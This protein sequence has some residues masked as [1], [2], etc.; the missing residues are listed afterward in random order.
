MGESKDDTFCK[1][2]RAAT[3]EIHAVS[4]AL[5][6]AKLAF[7]LQDDKVWADGLL[8]FYDIFKY[9]E[10]TM[11]GI[12]KKYEI[13]NLISPEMERTKAFEEDLNYYLGNE[14]NKNHSSR[15]SVK[16]YLAHLKAVESTKPILLLAYVYHLY[17]GLLSGGIILRKKR[18]IIQ[19]ISPFKST[20]KLE[21]NR[22]TDFGKNSIYQL[23]EN[24]RSRMNDLAEG[25]D[26]ETKGQL[27][28]ES[29]V[30][31]VMNN[32]IIRS[33]RGASAVMMRKII[34]VVTIF[35]VLVLYFIFKR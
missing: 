24:F 11:P 18:Q 9:L 20:D 34:Y 7:G 13:D 26:D 27:I 14:W 8:V 2:M 25:L 10:Q 33:V 29:K 31:F 17:M 5:V 30:V 4:D 35:L 12:I 23:K 16:S 21:G 19:K 22:V 6:N 1:K 15:E 32:Q 28:E 3:R